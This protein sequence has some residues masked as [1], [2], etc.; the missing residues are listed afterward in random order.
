MKRLIIIL[1]V[2]ALLGAVSFELEA[3]DVNRTAVVADTNGTADGNNADVPAEWWDK[4]FLNNT[5]VD[6]LIALGIAL[7]AIVVARAF[8]LGS[9]IS[10]SRFM[11]MPIIGSAGCSRWCS[12]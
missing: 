6:W 12:R 7:G 9:P 5:I 11:G 2:L 10:I 8:G 4:K 1:G 3:Q